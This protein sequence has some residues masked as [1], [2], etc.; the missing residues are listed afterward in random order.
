MLTINRYFI[1]YQRRMMKTFLSNSY[2]LILLQKKI[3]SKPRLV[4]FN[5]SS[6]LIFTPELQFKLI[7]VWLELVFIRNYN[8]YHKHL[9]LSAAK[10]VRKIFLPSTIFSI[11][12]ILKLE[13]ESLERNHESKH[14]IILRRKLVDECK[15]LTWVTKYDW[16]DWSGRN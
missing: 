14:E 6:F 13:T 1:I 5:F 9:H 3:S 2:T 11:N 7:N 4:L 10:K 16:G 12:L 15:Y 8:Q